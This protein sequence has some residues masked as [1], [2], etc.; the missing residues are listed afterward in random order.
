MVCVAGV[1]EGTEGRWKAGNGA[2]FEVLM[3]VDDGPGLGKRDGTRL[4]G[5][6]V[7]GSDDGSE[8]ED[9]AIDVGEEVVKSI[10]WAHS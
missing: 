6:C 1:G 9:C 4:D 3:V 7:Y 2:G 5:E 10:F 8:G